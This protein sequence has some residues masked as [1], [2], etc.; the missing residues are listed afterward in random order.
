M[1]VEAEIVESLA[2]RLTQALLAGDA[3]RPARA[4][5]AARVVSSMA[6]A[7]PQFEMTARR[8]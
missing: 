8:A 4:Q 2:H 3:H 6:R 7:A 5:R 1:Q